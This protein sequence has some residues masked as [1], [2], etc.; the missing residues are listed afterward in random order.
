[1]NE[2]GEVV[3]CDG[4]GGKLGE[5]DAYV[6]VAGRGEGGTKVKIFDVDGEPFLI[7]RYGRVK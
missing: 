7:V 6:F 1:M 3:L 2:G 5:L 4:C